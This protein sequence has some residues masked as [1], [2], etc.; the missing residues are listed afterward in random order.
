MWSGSAAPRELQAD[1]C[2]LLGTADFVGTARTD[3]VPMY[4]N[5]HTPRWRKVTLALMQ[6]HNERLTGWMDGP[7]YLMFA[8]PAS[9]GCA[10]ALGLGNAITF[11]AWRHGRRQAEVEEE[12]A[13]FCPVPCGWSSQPRTRRPDKTLKTGT[14]CSCVRQVAAVGTDREWGRERR[15]D[16]A[17]D[18]EASGRVRERGRGCCGSQQ[19]CA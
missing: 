18:L 3:R 19:R 1:G 12:V 11:P 17:R 7:G 2:R 13:G 5:R 9:N 8:S 10:L 4:L 15:E 16:R 14:P 6:P